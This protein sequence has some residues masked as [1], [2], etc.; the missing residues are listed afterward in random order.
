MGALLKAITVVQVEPCLAD[1]S[2]WRLYA[3]S[4]LDLYKLL[5]RT[6]CARCGFATCV[7][8]ALRL[9]SGTAQVGECPPLQE[10][11]FS[12]PRLTLQAILAGEGRRSS[13]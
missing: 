7:A 6:N 11:E 8:F 13:A 10:P 1:P 3:A 9:A 5:P 2:E 4:A 12:K